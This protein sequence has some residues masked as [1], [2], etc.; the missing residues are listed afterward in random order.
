MVP[1]G[2]GGPLVTQPLTGVLLNAV[3]GPRAGSPA[4]CSTSRQVRGVLA[5][6]VFGPAAGRGGF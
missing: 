1:V 2:I 4:A 5:V 3:P 6:A